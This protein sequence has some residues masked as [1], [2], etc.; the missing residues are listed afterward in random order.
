LKILNFGSLNLDYVYSVDHIVLPGETISS[1]NLEVF[2]GGK[3]LNQSIA[4]ARAGVEVYHAGSIGADGQPLLDM[5]KENGVDTTYIRTVDD[6]SGNAIIQV[7]RTGQ[8]S[9]ILFGGANQRNDFSYIDHVLSHFT[10]GDWILLQNEVNELSYMIDAAAK[11]QMI[12][13]LN[14]SPYNKIIDSCNLE[15]VC[16]FIMNEIEGEMLTGKT[17]PVEIITAMYTKYPKANTVLTVGEN[18][19][20]YYDGDKT[21]YREAE[22]AVVVDTTAAGDTFTGYFIAELTRKS[23]NAL[24]TAN[25]AASIS[26]SKKGAASSIPR[27][28]ELSL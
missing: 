9:I 28:D 11:K 20:Y 13:A 5:C 7:D 10:A 17:N 21:H 15:N 27:K 6:R 4:L 2:C 22:K 3:G 16:L 26:V 18:G 1:K 23:K 25:L 24:E 8:N 12:I 14:P 19:A